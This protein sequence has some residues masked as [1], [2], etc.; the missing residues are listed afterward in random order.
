MTMSAVKCSV[1]LLMIYKNPRARI[2]EKKKSG[3]PSSKR[4]QF[5]TGQAHDA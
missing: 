4:K 2:Q 3:G 1:Y 5:L